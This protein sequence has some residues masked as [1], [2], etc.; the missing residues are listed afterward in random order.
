MNVVIPLK[1]DNICEKYHIYDIISLSDNIV[2]FDVNNK[3]TVIDRDDR[4]FLVMLNADK[5]IVDGVLK[6]YTGFNGTADLQDIRKRQESAI[7]GYK[8]SAF[9]CF[10]KYG[11]YLDKFFYSHEVVDG[12]TYEERIDKI[13]KPYSDDFYKSDESK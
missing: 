6:I 2:I 5:T 1:N 10:R 4:D 7:Y 3:K 12:M 11:E 9:K 8:N 13:P